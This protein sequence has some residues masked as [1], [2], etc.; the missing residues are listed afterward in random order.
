M[1]IKITLFILFTILSLFGI[2]KIFWEQE[3]K[4][5][6]PTPIPETLNKVSKGDTITLPIVNNSKSNL[7]LHFYNYECPCS[8]FNIK[9]FQ[10]L[11]K[12]HSNKVDF[13]AVI[14]A[15][16]S[17][18]TAVSEFVKKY[19]LGIP[20]IH[21]TNGEIAEALGVYSTPHAVII[22]NH[23][24]YYKGNYNKARFCLSKNTKFAEQALQALV[25]GKKLPEF[26]AVAEIAHGCELP[27]NNK[28]ETT[29]L[30]LFNL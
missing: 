23:S 12:K 25:N 18:R 13:V 8:R 29:F 16:E 17:N 24:V 19:D 22:K 1:K 30:N 11:V 6:Q 9:E 14:Q 7:Y 3:Y 4:F 21:D 20:V 15:S 2:G 27:S 28:K 10:S 26:P 5:A